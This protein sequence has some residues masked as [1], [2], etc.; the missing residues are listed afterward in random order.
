MSLPNVIPRKIA[1]VSINAW[2]MYNFRQDIVK[3]FIE[4][5]AEV[6]IIA[7]LDEFAKDLEAMGCRFLPITLNNRSVNPWQDLQYYLT[8]KRIYRQIQPDIIF[9]Y[10]IK[11]NI[12]GSLAAASLG[13]PSVA[14]VTG[15]GYVFSKKNIL[16]WIVRWLYTRA[17][18][19]AGEVWFLN[20]EDAAAF[21]NHKITGI[22]KIKVLPGEGVN[23]SYFAPGIFPTNNS[24]TFR[25]LM[26]CRLL[27][28]KGVGVF[29]DAC[30]ILRKKNY[31]FESVLIGFYEPHHPD[32]LHPTDIRHWEEQGLLS[33]GG[34]KIDVRPELAKAD[35][36]IFPSF[37]LEGVPRGLME[38]A[39]MELPIIT[40]DARGCRE[41][42]VDQDNGF[43]CR[44]HDPFDLAAK[45]EKILLLEEEVRKSMG[46]SGRK[47]MQEMF[48]VEKI[49]SFYKA[50]TASP[51]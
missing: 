29:A 20:N 39:S 18:K 15:L 8:L 28:T 21:T 17:L 37:Y 48:G 43:L 31:A 36:F 24:G 6:F 12:Y 35:C 33:Y 4:T 11:P 34:F 3:Y 51:G 49:L 32:A 26:S 45:M 25:F 47:R 27:K 44:Q 46:R 10:V 14:V 23:T 13:I 7:A 5:G 42:V 19:G 16:Y 38:A 1:F 2:S 40:V 22:E 50:V 9:H 41:V 30:R